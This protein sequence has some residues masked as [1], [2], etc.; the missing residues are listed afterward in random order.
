MLHAYVRHLAIVDDRTHDG[1]EPDDHLLHL[2]GFDGTPLEQ[3]FERVERSLDRPA[4]GPFL[5]IGRGYFVTLAQ[6][7]D[8][9]RWIGLGRKSLKKII[10]SGED[11]GN[12]R[13]AQLNQKRGGNTI[14]RRHA[15]EDKRFFD[16][17]CVALP[18]RKARGLL[19]RVVQEPSHLLRIETCRAARC[20]RRTE[21]TGEAVDGLVGFIVK[22]LSAEY[23]AHPARD[24]IAER[25]GANEAH[26]VDSEL[27]A[28][29]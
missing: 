11:V 7:F 9:L 21:G 8:E 3:D 19:R 12:P 5:D 20:G 13:A 28:S 15:G 26:A 16:V 10:G 29:C 4:H 17:L 6:L 14:P 22:Q 18:G 1:S 24:V 2:I 25:Y 23:R 27:L